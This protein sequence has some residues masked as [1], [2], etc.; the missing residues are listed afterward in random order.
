MTVCDMCSRTLKNPL[1]RK[2]EVSYPVIIHNDIFQIPSDIELS[3]CSKC[4][5]KLIRFIQFEQARNR[6]GGVEE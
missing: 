3:L 4:Q 1:L 2:G 5:R 6:K